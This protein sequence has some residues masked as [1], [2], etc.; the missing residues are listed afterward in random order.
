M[1]LVSS[2]VSRKPMINMAT[3]AVI[4]GALGFRTTLH[5]SI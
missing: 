5:A 2:R 4:D 3:L 1:V